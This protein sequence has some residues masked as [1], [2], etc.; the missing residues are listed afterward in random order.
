MAPRVHVKHVLDQRAL[1][2]L[3]M[4]GPA[5]ACTP[6]GCWLL[7]PGAP[8]A[9]VRSPI[10]EVV[11]YSKLGPVLINPLGWA[12]HLGVGARAPTTGEGRCGEKWL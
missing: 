12:L 3:R 5:T 4:Q 8:S 10:L 2:A 6:N 11:S 9:S 1:Q 7:A